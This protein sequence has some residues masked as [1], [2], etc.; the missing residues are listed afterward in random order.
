M[1][2]QKST[3]HRAGG[4]HKKIKLLPQQWTNITVITD[5]TTVHQWASLK[6]LPKDI[7]RPVL[8]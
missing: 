8:R 4:M 7:A 6:M 2:K 5:S 3:I 1:L